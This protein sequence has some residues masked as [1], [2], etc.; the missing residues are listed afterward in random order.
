MVLFNY[1]FRKFP[2]MLNDFAHVLMSYETSKQIMVFLSH[3]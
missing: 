2:N 1:V 3:N